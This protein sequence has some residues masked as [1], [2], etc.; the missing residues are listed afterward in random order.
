M[1]IDEPEYNNENDLPLAQ[2]MGDIPWNDFL[3]MDNRNTTTADTDGDW[4]AHLLAKVAGAEV[5]NEDSSEGEDEGVI[6]YMTMKEAQ[7]QVNHIVDACY[8]AYQ[9]ELIKTCSKLQVQVTDYRLLMAGQTMQQSIYD[10]VCLNVLLMLQI[11][12]V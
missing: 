10:F 5:E 7:M 2:L 6:K 1:P 8:H 9:P 4:E 11:Y 12:C 3:T